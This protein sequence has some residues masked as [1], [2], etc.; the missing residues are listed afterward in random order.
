MS[1]L[2]V[3]EREGQI[4]FFENFRI[5]WNEND[6]VLANNTDGV[7]NVN[8]LEFKLNI[9]DLNKTLFQAIKYLSRM[10]VK[11]ES[12]PANII[13]VSL[14]TQTA[15]L[16]KSKDYF[17]EIHTVYIG[18]AS[19]DNEGFQAGP[20]TRKFQYNNDVD[21]IALKDVLKEKDFMPIKIDENCIVGW[22]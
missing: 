15:Y 4:A 14:N 11:G 17:D 2:Y 1:N 10:R 21:A 18:A 6:E 8:L 12:V 13:L 22:A 5:P 7:W 16:Y 3:T 9:N 19:K 20:Y